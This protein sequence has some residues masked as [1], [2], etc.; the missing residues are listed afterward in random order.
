MAWHMK[1]HVKELD[2]PEESKVQ[3]G[4]DSERESF[5]SSV[6]YSENDEI[7]ELQ[8]QKKIP[9][10]KA[11]KADMISELEELAVPEGVGLPKEEAKSAVGAS[12][13]KQQETWNIPK[14]KKRPL[15]RTEISLQRE[16]M[17]KTA[18]S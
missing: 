12:R 7:P 11:R 17:I 6:A 10:P 8:V 3:A 5:T 2:V 15:Q 9:L 13:L 1:Y 18:L 4:F 14:E 16:M